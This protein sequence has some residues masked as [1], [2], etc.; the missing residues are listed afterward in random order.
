[1]LDANKARN[2]LKDILNQ[3]E[4]RIYYQDSKS[5]LEVWWEKAKEWI[6]HL[7]QKLFPSIHSA[8]KASGPILIA[9]IIAVLILLGV[10]IFFI[11][12]HQRRK[13]MLSNRKPLQSMKEMNWSFQRH[14]EEAGKQEALGEYSLSTRHLFLAL[15]L[16]FHEQEWLVARIWKT[17]WDYYDE[18]RKVNQQDAQQFYQLATFFDEVT[19]GGRQV[20]REEYIEFQSEVMN[21]LGNEAKKLGERG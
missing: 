1:M 21:W 15:L 2:E 12:R 5:L 7:L 9:V 20:R 17:N 4:Y 3:K 11:I 13:R 6:A 16:Y 14:L 8:S 10:A 18:L 19:Y